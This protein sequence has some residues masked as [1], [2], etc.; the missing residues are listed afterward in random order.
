M[1]N[2]GLHVT[3][4]YTTCKDY[5]YTTQSTLQTETAYA[6]KDGREKAYSSS[7]WNAFF[8]VWST[9]RCVT[10]EKAWEEKTRAF[11]DEKART[12]RS[13]FLL[14]FSSSC[15]L[16]FFSRAFFRISL[17]GQGK[18]GTAHDLHSTWFVGSY[19]VDRLLAPPSCALSRWR[20]VSRVCPGHV[21]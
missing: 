13:I 18:R 19:L 2:Y 8:Q 17:N 5:L 21:D 6:T 1:V 20:T 10:R 4:T 3:T 15:T 11:E 16:Q 14:A 7:D 12:R 9:S